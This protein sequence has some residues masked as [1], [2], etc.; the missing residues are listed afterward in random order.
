M[1]I[2]DSRGGK[3]QNSQNA[4]EHDYLLVR[5]VTSK[6]KAQE[7]GMPSKPASVYNSIVHRLYFTTKLDLL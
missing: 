4:S 7:T 2:Q 6:Y 3:K 1:E 5:E